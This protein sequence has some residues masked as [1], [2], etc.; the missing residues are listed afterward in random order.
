MAGL[1]D[2]LARLARLRQA[3]EAAVGSDAAGQSGIGGTAASALQPIAEFGS[4]PGD[5]RM[6]Q[7]V[8]ATLP[9]RP[10]LMVCLHGCTQTAASY[11]LGSGWSEQAERRGFVAIFPEQQKRN[12]PQNCFNWF[13]A[14][15]TRRDAGEVLSIR[16]MIDHA[17]AAH[18]VDRRRIFVVGLSAGAAM[19]SSL[20]AAY[21]EVF[22]A[23][24]I[25]AGL[26]HGSADNLSEALTAM[27]RSRQQSP[28]QWGDAVRQASPH[29]GSRPRV[30]IWH[31]T[32]DSVVNAANAETGF[33]QAID[34]HGLA[35]AP[36]SDITSGSH[37][38]RIWRDGQKR[39]VVEAHTIEGMGHGVALASEGADRC[40]Q[41][42]AY[43]FDVGISS[44]ARILDFFGITSEGRE[45]ADASILDAGAASAALSNQQKS[46]ASQAG[47][48]DLRGPIFDMLQET[49]VLNATATGRRRFPPLSRDVH[50]IIDAALRTAGLTRKK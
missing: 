50:R 23:G 46:G 31:G 25:V 24:A 45:M 14:D 32:A 9:Q 16:Q 48:P 4:N 8:P 1:G 42:G 28:R 49:G 10:A 6:F 37:R 27:A 30:A 12:N 17:V 36:A 19:A 26:P 47:S 11:D 40:G 34:V 2:N 38:V 35:S 33:L 43:S 5:L 44:T 7:Y 15:D 3:L 41:A 21:P 20:L 22:A 18:G 13:S 29:S 39:A